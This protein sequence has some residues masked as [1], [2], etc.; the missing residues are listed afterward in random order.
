MRSPFHPRI[1]I[2]AA[3][4]MATAAAAAPTDPGLAGWGRGLA[5]DRQ[6]DSAYEVYAPSRV[7]RIEHF[8][9]QPGMSDGVRA[10]VV[11]GAESVWVHLGPAVFV[12]AQDVK[13]AVGDLVVVVGSHV[14]IGG[15]SVILAARVQKD[16]RMLKL[17]DD[18]G[19]PAWNNWRARPAV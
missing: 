9:P 16:G 1:L 15:E 3:V 18:N 4:L 10:F 8:V 17:R 2:A 14:R 12:E 6:Y 19:R 13:L 5:Y 7:L 11:T